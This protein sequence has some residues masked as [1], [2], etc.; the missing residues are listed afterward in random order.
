MKKD[1]RE[2]NIAIFILLL[3]AFVGMLFLVQSGSLKKFG[4]EKL[5]FSYKKSTS[6]VST[7]GGGKGSSGS[8][9]GTSGQVKSSSTISPK[10]IPEGF[11]LEQLSSHFKKITISSVSGGSPRSESKITLS[12]SKIGTDEAIDI[13]GWMIKGKKSSQYIPKA[14]N[15]YIPTG[16]AA[17]SDIILKKGNVVYMYS[18]ESAIGINL[19]LNK[20]IGYLNNNIKFTPTLPNNCPKLDLSEVANVSDECYKYVRSIGMCKLPKTNLVLPQNDY[21]CRPFLDKVNYKGCYDAHRTDEDFL[22]KEW[23]VWTGYKFLVAE[24]DQVELYDKN[25]LLVDLRKY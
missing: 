12:G 22:S 19:H 2:G 5:D 17:E 15:D 25:G 8:G 21:G 16:T 1:K 13:T 3:I 18:N 9:S 7:S 24:V 6:T 23:R 4:I 10:S 20:C 11:T 14:V